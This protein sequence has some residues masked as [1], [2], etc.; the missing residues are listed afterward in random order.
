MAQ[1]PETF[2]ALEG[3]AVRRTVAA[4]CCQRGDAALAIH[5]VFIFLQSGEMLVSHTS[6][7]IHLDSD[8]LSGLFAAIRDFVRH[9]LGR[10]MRDFKAGDYWYHYDVYQNLIALGLT[11]DTD[12][13]LQVEALLHSLN[14]MFFEKFDR[15]LR[16]WDHS[17][18]A[19]RVFTP[20][21]D[22]L[23]HTYHESS[24][25]ARSRMS[26][27]E[28][29]LTTFG[30]IL[31]P[32]LLGVLAGNALII[33]G[34]P[35]KLEELSRAL[36]QT[37]RY[38]VPNMPNITDVH[39]AQGILDSLKQQPD[40][41]STVLGVSEKVYHALTTKEHL[42]HHVFLSLEP[43]PPA[44]LT[45]SDQPT[46]DIARLVRSSGGDLSAQ[47]RLL[48]FQL[49]LLREQLHTLEQLRKNQ[50]H[51]SSEQQREILHIDAERFHLLRY[52]ADRS[53]FDTT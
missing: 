26:S 51:L 32:V 52:L 34:N 39:M 24:E 3:A 29:L 14:V 5:A 45:P 37:L 46:L 25:D 50:P 23:L 1:A 44:C 7:L 33:R 21:I 53:A 41:Q 13:K 43:D 16:K 4:R 27:I 40:Y 28:W 47:A 20:T 35:A 38:S 6:P 8:L 31:D 2:I 18:D 10:E 19:F 15:V 17:I 42:S 49:T 30:T 12:D 22:E 36:K 9:T 48:D 11:D